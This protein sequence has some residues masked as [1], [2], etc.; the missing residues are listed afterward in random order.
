VKSI[1]AALAVASGLAALSAPAHAAYVIDLRQVG[2]D[3][4]AT[5]SGS[6][7]LAGL[8]Y[9][10]SSNAIPALAPGQD[11]LHIGAEGNVNIFTGLSGPT[12]LGTVFPATYPA[13]SANGE[14]VGLQKGPTIDLP[15]G[16]KS[17]T[18]LGTS[19]AVFGGAS[20]TNEGI[21]PGTYVWTWGQGADA[22]SLTINAGVPEPATWAMMILGV[23]MI[24]FALRRRSVGPALAA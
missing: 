19:T 16:Y 17:G 22:D 6:I 18:P 23:A 14:T 10:S 13:T 20:L 5:G 8:R 24:G 15:T 7:D 21:A 3:L 2:D 9:N 12:E 4:V 1:V 11:F